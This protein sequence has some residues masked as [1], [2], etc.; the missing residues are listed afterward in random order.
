MNQKY[1]ER[2]VNDHRDLVLDELQVNMDGKEM[3]HGSGEIFELLTDVDLQ[4]LYGIN[5]MK[6]LLLNNSELTEE[7]QEKLLLINENI[8]GLINDKFHMDFQADY[9][10]VNDQ[11]IFDY[12]LK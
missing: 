12:L 9:K 7:I 2:I 4:Y 5:E 10:N 11:E 3:F 1:L 8:I 6:Y